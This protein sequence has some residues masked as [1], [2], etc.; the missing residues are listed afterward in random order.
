MDELKY[1]IE[2]FDY[3]LYQRVEK[4]NNFL[5]SFLTG[6]ETKFVYK[7]IETDKLRFIEYYN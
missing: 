3:Y 7:N 1:I 2:L 6:K 4:K 5:V